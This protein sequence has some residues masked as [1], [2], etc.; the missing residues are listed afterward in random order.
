[1]QQLTG[2]QVRSSDGFFTVYLV[3]A[4]GEEIPPEEQRAVGSYRSRDR[5][6]VLSDALNNGLYSRITQ[7]VNAERK[8]RTA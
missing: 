3:R 8:R 7:A 6:Q 4:D 1:M 2:Y 5:A